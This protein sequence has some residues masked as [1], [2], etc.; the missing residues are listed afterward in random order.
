[1]LLRTG[2]ENKTEILNTL[3]KY[4]LAEQARRK[5][6]PTEFVECPRCR[7]YHGELNNNDNLCESCEQ[8]VHIMQ[9]DEEHLKKHE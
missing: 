9:W 3:K 6:L 4:C 1:M 7:G 8:I 2:L 5:V